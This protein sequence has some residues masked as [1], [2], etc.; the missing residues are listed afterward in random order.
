MYGAHNVDVKATKLSKTV[1]IQPKIR[2]IE[3]L[4]CMTRRQ[5]CAC[6]QQLKLNYNYYKTEI[7]HT[8]QKFKLQSFIE[9]H[10]S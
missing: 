7:N 10:V 5:I 4:H 8:T 9:V 1:F 2:D 3:K 6:V